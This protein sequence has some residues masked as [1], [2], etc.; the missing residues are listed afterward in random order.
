MKENLYW[1][2]T[3]HGKWFPPRNLSTDEQYIHC[4][5]LALNKCSIN[6]FKKEKGRR[7]KRIQLLTRLLLIVVTLSCDCYSNFTC[8]WWLCLEGYWLGI[9]SCPSVGIW[10]FCHKTDNHGPSRQ[11]NQTCTL[12]RKFAKMNMFLVYQKYVSISLLL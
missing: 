2:F 4:L 11:M 7:I 5:F 10:C 3:E 6:G 9:L 8:F 12:Q 1:C